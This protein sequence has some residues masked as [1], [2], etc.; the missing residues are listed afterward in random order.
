MTPAKS[1]GFFHRKGKEIVSAPPATR[2]VGEEAESNHS[3]EEEA[4]R[5]PE[6]NTLHLLILG[7]TFIPISQRFPV[8]THSRRLALCGS[9]FAGEIQT[10][11]GHHWPPRS[12]I[13]SFARVLPSPCLSISSLG[14]V[15]P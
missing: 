14:R 15:L 9:F 12:L 1:Q 6:V 4:Q 13:L 11:L 5:D 2:D 3:N 10:F 7:M 8:I